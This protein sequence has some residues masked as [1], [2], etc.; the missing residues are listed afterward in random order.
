[1]RAADDRRR[2]TRLL[3]SRRWLRVALLVGNGLAQAAAAALTAVAVQRAFTVMTGGSPEATSVDPLAVLAVTA[4]LAVATAGQAWLRAA[5]R[6]VAERLGQSYV[7]ELRLELFDHLASIS[8]RLLSGATTGAIGLR[9]VGD[10]SAL[11][12]WISLG[13]ARLAVSATMVTGT[14][15]ALALIRPILALAAGLA[16]IIGGALTMG[17]GDELREAE[18]Q[19]RRR[20]SRLAGRVTELVATTVAVQVNG[21]VGRERTR[22]RRLS[23]NLQ[24]AMVRRADRLGRL[25]AVAEATTGLAAGLVLVTGLATGLPASEVAAAMAVMSLLVPQVRGLARVHHHRQSAVVANDAIDRFLARPTGFHPLPSTEPDASTTVEL[26]VRRGIRGCHGGRLELD[27]VS[28]GGAVSSVTATIPAGTTVAIVGGNG[29]G[30]ST[31]LALLARLVDPNHGAVRLDGVN[32]RSLAGDDLRRRVAYAGVDAGL[33]RGSLRRNL[34][35]RAPDADDLS[36]HAVVRACGLS[37]LIGSLPDGLGTRIDEGGRNLS[38][39]QRQRIQLAR[40]LLGG[41]D[42]LLLDEADANLDADTSRLLDRVVADRVGTTV[43]ATHRP[44]TA[45]TADIVW[46]LDGGRL[47]AAGPPAELLAPGGA[48]HAVFSPTGVLPDTLSA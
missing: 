7:H 30:K 33:L 40:A 3:G 47:V 4:M 43:L 2:R 35:Y 31:L 16:V 28:M 13:V 19:A 15:I 36:L 6:V 24:E 27:E 25:T 23:D 9:F 26:V 8:P 11:R 10:V 21:A 20:R 32:I 48:A 1:M 29:A 12:R 38:A 41:P 39:G 18:R 22:L 46:C 37:P 34:T 45:A 42:V 17:Q 5:E 44:E 14:L